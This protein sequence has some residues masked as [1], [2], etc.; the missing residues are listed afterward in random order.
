M[1]LTAVTSSEAT[2]QR[3]YAY[4]INKTTS[5]PSLWTALVANPSVT[6]MQI[7]FP[8]AAAFPEQGCFEVDDHTGDIITVSKPTP[9][10]NLHVYKSVIIDVAG[11]Q[12][13]FSTLLLTIPSTSSSTSV[14]LYQEFSGAMLVLHGKPEAGFF[15]T[16]Y[17]IHRIGMGTGSS[18]ALEVPLDDAWATGAGKWGLNLNDIS[19]D[20][21]GRI[22]LNNSPIGVYTVPPA[23]GKPVTQNAR[24]N[25]QVP[26]MLPMT[27]SASSNG[28]LYVGGMQAFSTMHS[29]LLS[30]IGTGVANILFL[31]IR[32]ICREESGTML[33]IEEHPP[34]STTPG[35]SEIWRLNQDATTVTTTAALWVMP[36]SDRFFRISIDDK[37]RSPL[38]GSS[39]STSIGTMPLI[40]QSAQPRINSFWG[41]SINE[42]LP[43]ANCVLY[44][45]TEIPPLG[46][47]GQCHVWQDAMLSFPAVT[48][49]G[50]G[51][52]TLVQ[53]IPN[54]PTLRG[55][56]YFTQWMVPDAATAA[57]FALSSALHSTVQ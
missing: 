29:T 35:I 30:N 42:A 14:A 28:T 10:S 24:L 53:A 41:V 39:C 55:F 15:G 47:G 56:S 20:R 33:V 17:S 46:I 25:Y 44:I 52:A 27:V 49:N 26:G 37:V 4:G 9:T 2:S 3:F 6:A 11:T 40:S 19:T 45:G 23:G 34:L 7:S 50:S 32:D 12:T 38:Y 43:G 13:A 31:G 57:G 22:Y 36:F 1:V 54:D 21:S 51:D 5:V 16:N 48:A 8:T 18:I